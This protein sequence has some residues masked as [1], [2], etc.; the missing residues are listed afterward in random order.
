VCLGGATYFS[1]YDV[2]TVAVSGTVT[3]T[4]HVSYKI[5]RR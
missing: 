1:R 4:S 5:R 3:L 2:Y